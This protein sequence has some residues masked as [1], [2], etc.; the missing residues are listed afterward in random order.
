MQ[1]APR[2]DMRLPKL[3]LVLALLATLL[4]GCSPFDS[5]ARL[6]AG[7][8]VDAAV[9]GP[10]DVY[11]PTASDCDY[12]HRAA[13]RRCQILFHPGNCYE[14]AQAAYEACLARVPPSETPT[15]TDE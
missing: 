2:R 13:I 14:E 3:I 15:P 11:V 4:P 5:S 8:V 10:P 1:L 7:E 6:D 9:D 12:E